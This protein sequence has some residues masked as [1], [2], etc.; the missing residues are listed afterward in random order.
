MKILLLMLSI[1]T[2]ILGC[3]SGDRISISNPFKRCGFF[4]RPTGIIEFCMDSAALVFKMTMWRCQGLCL[5]S[6][7]AVKNGT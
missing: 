4:S 3:A 7:R 5:L 2:F 6:L 1:A